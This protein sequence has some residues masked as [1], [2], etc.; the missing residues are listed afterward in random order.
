VLS[1]DDPHAAEVYEAPRLLL[2]PDLHVYWRGDQLPEDV[3][4][5]A[6][7]ATGHQGSFRPG[8]RRTEASAVTR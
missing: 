8:A 6:Q 5:L 1:I 7:A 4:E 2:R 3:M